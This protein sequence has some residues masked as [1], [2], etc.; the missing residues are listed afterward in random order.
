MIVTFYTGDKNPIP[1]AVLDLQ[2]DELVECLQYQCENEVAEKDDL[3]AFAPHELA[4]RCKKCPRP[5]GFSCDGA[6][7]RLKENVQEVTFLVLDLDAPGEVSQAMALERL[8][9]A[10]VMYESPSSVLGSPRVRVVA[11]TSR[12]MIVAECAR[13]RFAFAELLGLA[14]GCGVE[15]AKDASKLFFVGRKPGTAPRVCWTFEGAPVDVDALLAAPLACTWEGAAASAATAT[16][17]SAPGGKADAVAMLVD[18]AVP[19]GNASRTALHAACKIAEV[20]GDE[21]ATLEVLARVWGPRCVPPW[22]D[23]KGELTRLARSGHARVDATRAKL[24]GVDAALERHRQEPG[25]GPAEGTA[26]LAL[27]TGPRGAVLRTVT[28]VLRLLEYYGLDQKI[29]FD[30]TRGRIVVAGVAPEHADIP[31]GQWQDVYTVEVRRLCERHELEVEIS[32]VHQA[33]EMQAHR[34]RFNPMRDWL[35]Q[36]AHNWDGQPRVDGAL[37]RYWGVRDPHAALVSRVWLLSLVARMLDPGCEVQTCLVML[38]D[39]GVG[40][41]R[42]LKA[43]VGDEW[44]ADSP[45]PIGDKDAAQIIRGKALWELGEGAIMQKKSAEDVK[46]F[47]SAPFDTYRPTHGRAVVDVPRTCTFVLTV[48]PNGALLHDP[49]G[50][51]RFMPVT[52]G[53]YVDVSAVRRDREQIL[54][55]AV[56]RLAA[57]EDFYLTRDGAAELAPAN[58]SIGD[59]DAWEDLL[60]DW[61]TSRPN[62]QWITW[63][64]VIGALHC[65]TEDFDKGKQMRLGACLRRMGWVRAQRSRDGV[66]MWG[67]EVKS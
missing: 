64:D 14:P 53:A 30:E 34:S 12:P 57:G 38:G 24:A 41:S 36:C 51:R 5:S 6:L 19:D 49:T 1:S 65:K 52:V 67:Y 47:L 18:F 17:V 40:K 10:A 62:V 33:I 37:E 22:D 25:D 32:T 7:H 29:R 54:G 55:E 50:A 43:L 21:A 23:S 59:H 28:N 11:P 13:A 63:R 58:E 3:L 48:N 26:A 16:A 61:F 56:A 15:G 35:I 4:D 2:W 9:L 39:Q 31:D 44:F 45:L 20:T 27:D 42:S 46:A 8:G 66:Q 60:A